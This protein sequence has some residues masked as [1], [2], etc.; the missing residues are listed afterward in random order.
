MLP[1]PSRLCWIA[2][3]VPSSEPGDR[4]LVAWHLLHS[5]RMQEPPFYR[6]LSFLASVAI[7]MAALSAI[8]LRYWL[9]TDRQSTDQ[10]FIEEGGAGAISVVANFKRTQL[11][12][13]RPGQSAVITVREHPDQVLRGHVDAID[14][15]VG[16]RGRG[17]RVSV[18]IVIDQAPD[19][20]RPLG[21]GTPVIATVVVR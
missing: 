10:A 4:R 8:G 7:L 20:A 16:G 19:A 14:E 12:G 2:F 13:I 9:A 1:T 5:T 11:S 21:P 18:R 6:R 17:P 15:R 3:C